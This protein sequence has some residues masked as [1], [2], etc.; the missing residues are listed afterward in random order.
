MSSFVHRVANWLA[1]EVMVKGLAESRWFQRF[2][3]RTH[4]HVERLGEH[5]ARGAERL[6]A[7]APPELDHL[8]KSGTAVFSTFR[9]TLAEEMAKA[10]KPETTAA[11]SR[12]FMSSFAR[13]QTRP[14][15]Q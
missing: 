5:A 14:R 4:T 3:L 2:V 1:T 6:A 9:R 7:S 12:G 11:Q 15:K 10:S 8:R 13:G